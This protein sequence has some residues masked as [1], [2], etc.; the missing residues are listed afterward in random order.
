MFL[1]AEKRFG[2]GDG[3]FTVAEQ[4]NL[5]GDL[6]ERSNGAQR[7]KTSIQNLRLGLEFNF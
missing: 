1:Q 3:I 6:Y 5:Y 2:N 4:R 7:L